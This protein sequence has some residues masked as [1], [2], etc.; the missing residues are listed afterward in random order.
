MDME[1][2]CIG[3]FEFGLEPELQEPGRLETMPA[4]TQSTAMALLK[5][6][7]S[8]AA[9][10]RE[11][12]RYESKLEGILQL[13]SRVLLNGDEAERVDVANQIQALLDAGLDPA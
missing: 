9:K 2:T 3:D 10:I 7:V 1:A 6:D 12:V 8:H 13:A 4:P 11:H 5:Q